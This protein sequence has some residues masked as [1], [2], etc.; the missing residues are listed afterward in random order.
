MTKK[1]GTTKFFT[2]PPNYNQKT[3]G[4]I[5]E[6]IHYKL[7]AGQNY[8]NHISPEMSLRTYMKFADKLGYELILK[9]KV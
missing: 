5:H 3:W 9:K 8:V 4:L 2:E 6:L 1:V 7:K